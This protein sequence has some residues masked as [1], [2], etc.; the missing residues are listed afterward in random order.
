MSA[1]NFHEIRKLGELIRD[2]R[3]CMLTSKDEDGHLRSRPMAAQQVEFD[4][5]LWFFTAKSTQ[6]VREVEED[7]RVNVSFANPEKQHYVSVSGTAEIVNDKAKAK[8]LWNE[9]YRAWF[10]KGLD[11]P[12]LT[13]M[14]VSVDKAEYWDVPSSA[15][16]HLFGYLKAVTTGE[17]P[18]PGEH[19][20]VEL[21][22]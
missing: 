2:V 6:K 1:E 17:R 10:P 14:K 19:A 12:E 9:A 13:L 3:I 20:K 22:S 18:S 5:D 8:E 7:R 16:V 15:M 21:R 11:D 4:G